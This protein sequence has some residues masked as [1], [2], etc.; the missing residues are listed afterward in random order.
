ML[1]FLCFLFSILSQ[2]SLLIIFQISSVLLLNHIPIQTLFVF[3]QI[4]FD[5]FTILI[6]W[7]PFCNSLSLHRCLKFKGYFYTAFTDSS[8]VS[9]FRVFSIFTLIEPHSL[10]SFVGHCGIRRMRNYQHYSYASY[11]ELL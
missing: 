9:D 10:I 2:L 1:V 8:V 4:L 11:F 3:L 5:S 6:F 7:L